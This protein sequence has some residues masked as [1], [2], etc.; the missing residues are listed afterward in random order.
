MKTETNQ[1]QTPANMNQPHGAASGPNISGQGIL[2]G[3]S[4]EYVTLF[5]GSQ[6]FG[7]PIEHVHDV[8]IASQIARVPLAPREIV[9]LLNLRG[10]VVTALS[11]RARLAMPELE[12]TASSDQNGAVTEA[13]SLASPNDMPGRGVTDKNMAIGIE[14]HGEAYALMVDRIG[15]VIRLD[16]STFEPNPVHLSPAW[17]ALSAGVHRL[18]SQILMILDVNAVLDFEA[19]MAA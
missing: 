14:H 10:R 1:V 18:G 8:F 9:G 15:E 11:L 3:N 2:D 12:R 5:L 6:M 4:R 19:D 16:S 7:L 13:H 17:L